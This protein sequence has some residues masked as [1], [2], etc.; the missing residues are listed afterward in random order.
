MSNT[1]PIREW[2]D[3]I[4]DEYLQGFVKDGGSSIKFAVPV[5][6]DL[7]LLFEEALKSMASSLEYRVV[8]VD[9]GQTRVHMPQEIFFRIAAQI[10]WRLLARRMVLR[11]CND[12]P[13]DTSA[14]D[15]GDRD[16]DS[17]GYCGCKWR[18]GKSNSP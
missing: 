10:D 11:L 3:V 14:I 16:L 8:S 13:Y 12:L 2:L 5:R 17:F 15:L 18:R 7:G 6:E 1:L 4:R 9:S